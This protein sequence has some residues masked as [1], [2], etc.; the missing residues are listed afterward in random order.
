MGKVDINRAYKL[1][2]DGARRCVGH[3]LGIAGNPT[4]APTELVDAYNRGYRDG[5]RRDE[6]AR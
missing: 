5:M 3:S 2:L 4:N 6:N 1:G